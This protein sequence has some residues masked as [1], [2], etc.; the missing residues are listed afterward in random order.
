VDFSDICAE[1]FR[2]P[3]RIWFVFV[4]NQ[5]L[6]ILWI[7]VIMWRW[8]KLTL[9]SESWQVMSEFPWNFVEGWRIVELVRFDVSEVW[10]LYPSLVPESRC[11]SSVHSSWME[12]KV[13]TSR[14]IVTRGAGSGMAGMAAAIPI[15]S[16]AANLFIICNKSQIKTSAFLYVS[17][18]WVLSCDWSRKD[19]KHS[20]KARVVY[21]YRKY[22]KSI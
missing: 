11:K 21:I 16:K 13:F 5:D 17:E 18:P 15:K 2:H 8:R 9:C 7:L 10:T 14:G 6:W 19:S 20:H 4:G 22:T 12:S 1:V 3:G